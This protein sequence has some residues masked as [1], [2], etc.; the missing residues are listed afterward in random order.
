[1]FQKV[2]N[3]YRVAVVCRQGDKEGRYTFTES[4]DDDWGEIAKRMFYEEFGVNPAEVSIIS[5]ERL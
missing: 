1:M 5:R 3:N 4:Y 2:K